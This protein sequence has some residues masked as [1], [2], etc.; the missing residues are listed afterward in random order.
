MH[1]QGCVQAGRHSSR[2]KVR[3]VWRWQATRISA[4]VGLVGVRLEGQITQIKVGCEVGVVQ[5]E[6]GPYAECLMIRAL[7][8]GTWHSKYCPCSSPFGPSAVR[9][10]VVW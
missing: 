5:R 10:A 6:P 1:H 8:D 7:R 3:L 9:A 2:N 4:V